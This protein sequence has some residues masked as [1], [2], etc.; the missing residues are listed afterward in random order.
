MHCPN[1]NS[2]KLPGPRLHRAV[3]CTHQNQDRGK[4]IHLHVKIIKDVQY[5]VIDCRCTNHCP[6]ITIDETDWS[7]CL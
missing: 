1:L 2:C 7:T 3:T 4:S 6:A 5:V